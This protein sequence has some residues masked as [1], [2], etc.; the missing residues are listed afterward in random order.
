MW[1]DADD[2]LDETNRQALKALKNSL[3]ADVDMVMMPYVAAFDEEGK[4]TLSYERERIV[5]RTAN[6][7]WVGAVHEVIVPARK[8]R[9]FGCFRL[10]QKNQTCRSGAQFKDFPKNARGR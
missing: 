7:S 8:R 6:F 3:T 10:S 1:L 4:P 5:R 2:V 9:A